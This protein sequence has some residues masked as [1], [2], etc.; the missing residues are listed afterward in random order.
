M[1]KGKITIMEI[2][3]LYL[4]A[5]LMLITIGAYAQITNIK[6]G[7]IITEYILILL[8]VIIF[9]KVK[10]RGIKTFLRFN[11]I[12]VKHGLL[13]VLITL[14]SYPIAA[15]GNVIVLSILSV[16]GLEIKPSPVPVADNFGEYIVLFF[17]VAIS[18]GICEEVF[19]RGLLLRA[20]EEKYK[21]AG[22][23]MTAILFGVFHFN[24]QNL[25][26]PIVLGLVFGY[27]VHI[28]DS[29]YAGIIGHITN[30]GIAV[31]LMYGL[32]VLYKKLSK[33]GDFALDKD[34]MPNS[35]QLLASTIILG[36]IAII[37]GV[38]VFLLIKHLKKDIDSNLHNDEN[39]YRKYENFS[40]P[41]ESFNS[42]YPDN[43][44]GSGK[45]E[46]NRFIGFIP[47]GIV[48]AL[49]IFF[50]YKQFS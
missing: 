44:I 35:A 8:P 16:L 26:A 18:A 14:L 38:L 5:A 42:Y 2:N 47:V 27:L 29:I 25:A 11:K 19:F 48:L 30:N 23:V 13:V 20:Y 45:K 9:L 4:V 34:T 28:T 39:N 43:Q 1:R 49:Y 32:T 46:D 40:I 24:L 3:V 12:R 22:I 7:L 17:I 10:G 41:S 15:L 33:Y 36:F 31:T 21:T 6:L 37:S 50:S